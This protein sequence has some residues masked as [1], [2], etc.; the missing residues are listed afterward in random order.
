MTQPRKP[1]SQ[2][3]LQHVTGGTTD[4][5]P[6]PSS[7]L[8]SAQH[9]LGQQIQNTAAEMEALLQSMR[10]EMD[11]RNAPPE[12]HGDAGHN[13][14]V[15]SDVPSEIFRGGGGSD[16][17]IGGGG[18][19][20]FYNNDGDRSMDIA[21]GGAGDDVF[22]WSP[23]SGSDMFLG[24][25]GRDTVAIEGMNIEQLKAAFMPEQPGL[26][27][28]VSVEGDFNVIT[29]QWPGGQPMTFNGAIRVGGEV[30]MV[31]GVERL[32]VPR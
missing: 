10:E 7:V 3:D 5:G 25:A 28:R 4:A 12:H 24:E 19:D 17:M 15:G 32:T 1:L 26:M 18:Q 20:I 8:D 31:N 21:L 14:L 6:I 13:V 22:V 27:W 30:L 29:C 23:G 16:T 9:A 11:R 2:A